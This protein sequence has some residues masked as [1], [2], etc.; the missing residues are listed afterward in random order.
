MSEWLVSHVE[1]LLMWFFA[2]T[3]YCLAWEWLWIQIIIS[4]TSKANFTRRNVSLLDLLFYL[5]YWKRERWSSIVNCLESVWYLNVISVYCSNSLS[6]SLSLSFARNRIL[7]VCKIYDLQRRLSSF[8]TVEFYG[9]DSKGSVE[10]LLWCRINNSHGI[11][12]I[13]RVVNRH[14]FIQTVAFS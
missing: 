10:L 8:K 12:T 11:L 5:M 6:L 1:K 7:C 13:K 4:L 2:E 9:Q 3:Y 14:T